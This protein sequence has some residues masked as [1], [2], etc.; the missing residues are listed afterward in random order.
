MRGCPKD[1]TKR[2]APSAL[3]IHRNTVA[4]LCGI[5]AISHVLERSVSIEDMNFAIFKVARDN[6]KRK[7]AD[8]SVMNVGPI[9]L[10]V[11]RTIFQ[12]YGFMLRKDI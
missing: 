8:G 10:A 11:L 7:I 12:Q 4:G 3:T 5:N 1:R 2:C 6:P 9:S